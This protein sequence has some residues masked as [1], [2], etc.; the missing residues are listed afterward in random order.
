MKKTLF[1]ISL[2]FMLSGCVAYY[3]Q[4]VDVP[5]INHKNDLRVDAGVSIILDIAVMLR[6]VGFW[7]E[8]LDVLAKKLGA[9]VILDGRAKKG[10]E[11]GYWV[12]PTVLDN[13]TADMKVCS[14]EV[15]GPMIGVASYDDYED[16]LARANDTRYGLQAAVFTKDLAKALRAADVLDF[17][18]VLINE[19]PSWRADQQPYGGVRDSGN[20]REGPAYTVQEMTER[21]VVIITP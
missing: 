15:F 8:H 18:G 6:P 17:G 4:L 21:R 1:L 5:L 13:V 9:K 10:D 19:M 16:A 14:D 3:P 12:G 7:H 20:T 2:V 11:Q